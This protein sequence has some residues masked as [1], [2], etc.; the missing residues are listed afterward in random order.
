MS[1]ESHSHETPNDP[2][3]TRWCVRW[4]WLVALASLV[5]AA[6]TNAA[7]QGFPIVALELAGTAERATEAVSGY[8]VD[9]IRATIIWDFLFLALYA[10]ALFCGA[11]WARK[12]FRGRTGRRLGFP[13][14][15]GGIV[16][17]LL[18]IIE[19]AAMLAYLAD[20]Q[21]WNGWIPIATATA[22]PKFLLVLVAIVYIVVGIV[23]L[24]IRKLFPDRD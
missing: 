19:N 15:I 7:A 23:L 13:I 21:G 5:A 22:I 3:S 16:A 10:P 12:Q 9:A 24:A 8:S 1:V 6:I 17:G 14:A 4:W 2:Q 18:D 20:P 11:L